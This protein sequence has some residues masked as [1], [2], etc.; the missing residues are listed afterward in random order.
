MI[1]LNN[2]I[3]LNFGERGAGKKREASL[4]IILLIPLIGCYRSL[5]SFIAA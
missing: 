3:M 5:M 1:M 2:W 4:S